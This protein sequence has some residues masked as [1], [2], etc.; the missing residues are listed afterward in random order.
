MRDRSVPSDDSFEGQRV[1]GG[2]GRGGDQHRPVHQQV[3]VD[4]V[5]ER[6]EQA[7][8]AGR[9]DRGHRDQRVGLRHPVEGVLEPA[10]REAGQQVVGDVVGQVAEFDHGDGEVTL[11]PYGRGQLVGQQPRGRRLAQTGGYDNQV[12]RHA[13]T[14]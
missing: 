7:A 10:G 4:D 6:L 1:A 9:E 3:L 11:G 2:A 5:E 8:V 12:A 13:A 14:S